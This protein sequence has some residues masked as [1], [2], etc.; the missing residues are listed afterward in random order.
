M[1]KLTDHG[2]KILDQLENEVDQTLEATVGKLSE[3][4]KRRL[5]ESMDEIR[6][7]LGTVGY[8]GDGKTIVREPKKGEP[9]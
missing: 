8:S 2:R 6:S 5:L 9:L 1:I 4:A 7:V 3:S